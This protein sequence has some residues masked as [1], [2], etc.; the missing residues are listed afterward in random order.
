MGLRAGIAATA[1]LVAGAHGAFAA[2]GAAADGARAASDAA[3][4]CAAQLIRPDT[5][6]D[7][8]STLGYKSL[9]SETIAEGWGFRMYEAPKPRQ[10]IAQFTAL[11]FPHSTTK[12]CMFQVFTAMSA[13]DVAALKVKL[14]SDADIGPLYWKESDPKT[15]PGVVRLVAFQRQDPSIE[16]NGQIVSANEGLATITLTRTDRK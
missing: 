9:Q 16:L 6:A 5:L 15:A 11:E 8:L 4:L 13:D 1:L 12:T 14:E 7:Q 10:A 2:D 3:T